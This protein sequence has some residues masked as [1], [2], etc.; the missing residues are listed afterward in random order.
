MPER[1][2]R[3][4]RVLQMPA[5]LRAAYD[6]AERDFILEFGK[7][8]QTTIF[9]TTAWVWLRRM[10]GG[11]VGGDCVWPAKIRELEELLCGE[12]GGEPVVVWC[13]F[14]QEIDEI[15]RRWSC[16][17]YS[18]KLPKLLR[19]WAYI[20][21]EVPLRERDRIIH[22]FNNKQL[23]VLLL[24]QKIAEF[25]LDLSAASASIY[26]SRHAALS[27]N[28]QCADRIVHP[29]KRGTLLHVDVVAEN[30]VDE[31]LLNALVVKQWKSDQL[32]QAD[33]LTRIRNRA[34]KR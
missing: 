30:S 34:A 32:M 33:L 14:N 23:R 21:G 18:G 13:A 16:G 10:C 24:Q 31:D 4:R 8:S 5:D 9:A 19:S 6:R 22:M 20:T 26:I 15:D 3:E 2:V 25:G 12:L 11:F 29:R 27:T 1:V 17:L 7:T 28:Q